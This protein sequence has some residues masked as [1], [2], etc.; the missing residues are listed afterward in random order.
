MNEI[1]ATNGQNQITTLASKKTDKE[2]VDYIVDKTIKQNSLAR[3]PETDE[4]LPMQDECKY[5][6]AAIK[7]K[8]VAA[9]IGTATSI[10]VALKGLADA[11]FDVWDTF[12]ERF[13]KPQTKQ[14]E[15][16]LKMMLAPKDIQ[17]EQRA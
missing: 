10:L 3:T 5:L 8:D 17:T 9:G 6:G 12:V 7:P 15:Q 4:F 13:G 11:G 1:S 2:F 16:V 14:E